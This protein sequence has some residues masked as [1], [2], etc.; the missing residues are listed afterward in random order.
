MENKE[1]P[2]LMAHSD[3]ALFTSK[4][5]QADIHFVVNVHYFAVI[6]FEL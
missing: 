6:S 2:S 5:V 3:V 4:C 1:A